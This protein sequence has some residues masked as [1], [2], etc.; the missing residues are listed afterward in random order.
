MWME[1]GPSMVH[2]LSPEGLCD[3]AGL[4]LVGHDLGRFDLSKSHNLGVEDYLQRFG[5][6]FK[7]E[8]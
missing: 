2:V 7:S 6:T 5:R 8:G 1:V 4:E 3:G